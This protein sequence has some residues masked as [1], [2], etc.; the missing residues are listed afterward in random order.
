MRA[1]LRF[2]EHSYEEQNSREGQENESW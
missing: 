1:A 2:N